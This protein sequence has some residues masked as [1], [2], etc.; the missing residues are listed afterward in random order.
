MC[1]V[2]KPRTLKFSHNV[3]SN[4]FNILEH[5]KIACDYESY[6]CK[7]VVRYIQRYEHIKLCVF[8]P[9]IC[10]QTDC[11][12]PANSTVY[13]TIFGQTINFVSNHLHVMKFSLSLKFQ[14]ASHLIFYMMFQ[15]QTQAEC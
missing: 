9:C 4:Q 14:H 5:M 2:C 8:P 10:P 13:E 6:G 3:E 15:H 12:F 1:I 7:D 11:N